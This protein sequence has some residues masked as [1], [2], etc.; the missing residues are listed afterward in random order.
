MRCPKDGL[1]AG[2]NLSIAG[3]SFKAHVCRLTHTLDLASTGCQVQTLYQIQQQRSTLTSWVLTYHRCGKKVG[4][5]GGNR[6]GQ[7]CL[8]MVL[9]TVVAAIDD[10]VQRQALLYLIP[11]VILSLFLRLVLP[12]HS[13]FGHV[14][15]RCHGSRKASSYN[16]AGNPL[17]THLR[18]PRFSPMKLRN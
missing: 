8:D 7:G 18:Q 6:I 3:E 12:V 17:N 5:R 2:Q 15:P 4:R 9:L 1:G 11:R 13:T 16:E 14:S 10:A